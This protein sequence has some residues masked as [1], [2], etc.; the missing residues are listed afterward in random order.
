MSEQIDLMVLGAAGQLGSELTKLASSR[1]M[2]VVGLG[3]RT[4]NPLDLVADRAGVESLL[5]TH[6]PRRVINCVAMHGVF[7]SSSASRATEVNSLPQHWLSALCAEI[8]SL[9]IYVSSDEVFSGEAECGLWYKEDSRRGPNSVYGLTKA[10]GE[11][12]T[13]QNLGAIARTSHLF[14]P[15]PT[16]SKGNLVTN[17]IKGLSEKK[18]LSYFDNRVFSPSYAPDVAKL[19]LKIES[20]GTYH[21]PNYGQCSA[22][23]F[24]KTVVSMLGRDHSHVE[25]ETF[26]RSVNTS[27]L[28]SF[29]V[30]RWEDALREFLEK[31][32]EVEFNR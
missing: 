24:A 10:L 19:L 31:H 5:L 3:P 4:D 17:I 2:S 14:G 25:K 13:E 28:P 22:Y 27:I 21:V 6:R 23:S 8:G 20:R 16:R 29:R 12:L 15:T 11:V 30:R 7:C 26:I 18:R 1:S 32:M 9:F